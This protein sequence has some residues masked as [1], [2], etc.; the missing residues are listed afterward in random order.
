MRMN[1]LISTTRQWNPG[2]EFILQGSQNILSQIFGNAYNP[3]IY[4]RNPDIRG[5]ARFRNKTRNYSLSYRWDQ[6][7]FKGKGCIHELLRIGHYDNSWKD[8]M[9]AKNID[10]AVFAGSPEW[11]GRRLFSMYQA[12][13]KAEIPAVFLGLG[14]GDCVDF[15]KSDPIV[16]RVLTNAKFISARD[17][18]T[19]TLL[20]KYNAIYMPCPALLAAPTNRIVKSVTKIGLIYA[21][22]ETLKGN[23]VSKEM[24]D[25]IVDLYKELAKSYDVELVCHYI[26]EIDKAKEELPNIDINYSY[27]S[28]DYVEIYNKFDFIIGGR[29]HGIGMCASLGI[30]GI[31][32]KHDSRS[33]TTD[34]FL[35]ATVE[36]GMPAKEVRRQI[37]ARC[38]NV[39]DLSRKLVEHKEITM[40]EYVERLS[41]KLVM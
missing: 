16:D 33:S 26:D 11:Y 12:I 41:E 25:Y 39:E 23:N 17:K 21:T 2:D 13:E 5:G 3:I 30:P 37:D 6:K 15:S 24:H 19:E 31:M 8:D 34:G 18:Q 29:V 9:N 40:R 1:V 36:I 20:K 7:S 35:A 22:H 38:A 28:K 10:L 4:N 14:A 32:I 27:D